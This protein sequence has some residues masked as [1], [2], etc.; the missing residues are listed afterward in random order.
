MSRL[1]GT[2]QERLVCVDVKLLLNFALHICFSG[3]AEGV[4]ESGAANS[5][6]D[7]LRG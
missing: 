6:L 1:P 5:G 3:G 7:H 2:V 4:E